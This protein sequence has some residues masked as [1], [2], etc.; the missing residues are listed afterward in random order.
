MRPEE[1]KLEAKKQ[2]YSHALLSKFKPREDAFSLKTQED[3]NILK[4]LKFDYDKKSKKFEPK[5]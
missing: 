5:L 2:V 3:V 1:V 4:K